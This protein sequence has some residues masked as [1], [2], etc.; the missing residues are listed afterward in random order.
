M[1][2]QSVSHYKILRQL[3]GGGMGKDQAFVWLDK[4]YEE[5]SSSLT[6]LKVDPELDSLRSD[7][8]FAEL[9]RRIGLPQ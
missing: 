1:I 7:S 6:A 2:G 4:A 5:R 8:R 3:G 9:L